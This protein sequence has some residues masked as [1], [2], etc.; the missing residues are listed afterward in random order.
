MIVYVCMCVCMYSRYLFTYTIFCQSISF[1]CLLLPPHQTSFGHL[2][3]RVT[4]GQVLG[5]CKQCIKFD[6]RQKIMENPDD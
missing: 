3:K 2:P 1:V 4:K 5:D 6:E